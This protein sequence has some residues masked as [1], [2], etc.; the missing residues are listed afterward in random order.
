[1]QVEGGREREKRST[2]DSP[3]FLSLSFL[4]SFSFSPFQTASGLVPQA[5]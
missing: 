1:M 2:A 5:K 3:F 4:V